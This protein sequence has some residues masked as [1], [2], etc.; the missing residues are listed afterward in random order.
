MAAQSVEPY[1]SAA[2]D[3]IGFANS[4]LNSAPA[5]QEPLNIPGTDGPFVDDTA[6]AYG[7][8]LAYNVTG[9]VKYAQKSRDFIM[10]WV[11]KTKTTPER[12]PR[13]RLMPDL[14]DHWARRP[15]LRLR[16]TAD[17]A[18]GRVLGGR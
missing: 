18:F 8:A 15:W 9:N 16:G 7:L 10:A 6:T 5:P 11:Q 1:Q 17:H 4:K 13:Q 14:A 2:N 3:V 12:L